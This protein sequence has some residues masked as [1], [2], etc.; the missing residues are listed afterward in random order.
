MSPELAARSATENAEAWLADL[1]DVGTPRPDRLPLPVQAV[2]MTARLSVAG[3]AAAVVRTASGRWA[4]IHGS[5]LAGGPE[6]AVVVEEASPRQLAPVRLAAF[7]LHR[8]RG[9]W[10]AD[11]E[12]L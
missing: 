8:S 3:E 9:R 6:V 5:R 4:R 11:R 1:P 12:E 7:G 10:T 2:A